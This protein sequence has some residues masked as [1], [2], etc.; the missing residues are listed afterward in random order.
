MQ[1]I[2]E[3]LLRENSKLRRDIDMLREVN[4]DLRNEIRS[5]RGQSFRSVEEIELMEEEF[6][7]M[8]IE[9]EG[10]KDQAKALKSELDDMRRINTRMK[11]V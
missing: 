6:E 10:V 9:A 7:A 2:I 1:S 5:Y 3:N 11:Q 8:K 4:I